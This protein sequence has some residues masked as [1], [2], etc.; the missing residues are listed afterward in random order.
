MG[1]LALLGNVLSLLALGWYVV[2]WSICLFGLARARAMF[3]VRSSSS[4]AEA[5]SKLEVDDEEDRMD[6][7]DDDAASLPC[8]SI[9]RPL[10]GIDCGSLSLNLASTFHLDYPAEK[11]EV[12]LSVAN[13]DDA[14]LPLAR[15]VVHR[16]ASSSGSRGGSEPR[17]RI[18]VGDISAGVN[19]KVNNLLRSY[20]EAKHDLLWVLDSQVCLHPQALR[21]SVKYLHDEPAPAPRPSPRWM[22]RKPHGPRVGLVHHVPLGVIPPHSRAPAGWGSLVERAFLGTTHAKMY[23]AIN[24]LSIESCVMGKSN[25]WRRSD[26]ERVSDT[27]FSVGGDGRREGDGEGALGSE[28]FRLAHGRRGDARDEEDSEEQDGDEEEKTELPPLTSQTA[29]SRILRLSRPLA[30]F[31]IYLAE[32]NMLAL[33]LFSPPLSL[34]HHLSPSPACVART[35]VSDVR[36]LRDYVG[37]RMR[38]IRVRRY[39]VPAATWIEPFTESGVAGLL[40][41][42]AARW[43]GWGI[44]QGGG[45]GRALGVL[46]VHFALWLLVDL[47]VLHALESGGGDAQLG[48][49]TGEDEDDEAHYE[50]ASSHR[51][52]ISPSRS[53]RLFPTTSSLLSF[54][55]AWVLRELLALPIWACA[56]WGG[57]EVT[58]RGTPYRILSDSRAAQLSRG[59]RGRRG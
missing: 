27:F 59:S 32:D 51:R 47:G 46:L 11:Y 57:N 43:R 53:R 39:M 49:A 22:N 16:Y 54:L 55:L 44:V 25:L 48:A 8:V 29:K 45:W 9:L 33:S 4:D 38:W 18:V 34:A 5:N 3:L 1:L 58:W 7:D 28:A 40:A 42:V 24:S 37:R 41:L 6:E 17:A 52:P 26:L 35:D 36:T 23:I 10:S 50:S 19:P 15:E 12:I 21:R 2:I 14:A 56:I 30:R 31:S 13:P 20:V